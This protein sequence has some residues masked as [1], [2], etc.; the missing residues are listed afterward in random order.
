MLAELKAIRESLQSGIEALI[1]RE[2][3][4]RQAEEKYRLIAE[5]THDWQYWL[6]PNGNFV[7][8]SPSCQRVS[9]Y[10]A[11]A[12]VSD[13][14][15]LA[16]IIHPDDRPAYEMH[17]RLVE[18]KRLPNETELR[19]IGPDG[20]CR[21]VAH[22]CQ[23]VLDAAGN[24]LGTLVN[25]RDITHSKQIEKEKRR[26]A[27]HLRQV[28]KMEALST[29]AEGIAHD[30]NNIL[31]AILGHAELSY[32][33]L[34]QSAQIAEV[35]ASLKE[36][37]SAVM[38]AQELVQQIHCFSGRMTPATRPVEL[39]LLVVG[40]LN[41]LR[42]LLPQ[43][44]RIVQ[45]IYPESGI[46]LAE[47]DMIHQ[48]VMNLC[49]NAYHAMRDQGGTLT[50][51]LEPVE[52]DDQLAQSHPD[53]HPGPYAR[54]TVSDTGCGMGDWL[55]ERIFEPY[56]STKEPGEGAGLG[57]TMVHSIVSGLGGAIAV[58]SELGHGSTF[59]VYF[60]R[61]DNVEIPHYETAAQAP[62]GK[63]HILFVDDEP[64]IAHLGQKLLEHFGY[65]VTAFTDSAAA[66]TAFLRQ[67]GS[68]DLVITDLTMPK[69]DGIELARELLHIRPDLK[70]ILCTGFSEAVAAEKIS[71]LKIREYL[72]KPIT[73]DNLVKTLR[74]VLA[75]KR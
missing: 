40:T 61:L 70:I 4:S 10:E 38:R 56:F 74:R 27:E 66:L 11:E 13:P 15:L 43:N 72:T 6:D 46:V 14:A 50:V 12:F 71:D 60:P 49:T 45:H 18:Q 65:Q 39:H 75:A 42:A 2:V 26:L 51:S 58:Q 20:A 34:S 73:A 21:W 1:R 23:P 63:A 52:V 47:P 69:M 59:Q 62:L 54:L 8:N 9:G 64:Q 16:R 36:I 67:S 22:A 3:A 48:V 31:S 41:R 17:R 44:I 32:L 25:N 55:L 35:R 37:L 7:Y 24:F 5:H 30:F 33:N 68:F 19:L 53:L 57:L 29:L 28:Q